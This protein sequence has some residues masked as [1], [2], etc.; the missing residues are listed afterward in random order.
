MRAYQSS[1]SHH[2]ATIRLKSDRLLGQRVCRRA[3]GLHRE[4][5]IAARDMAVRAEYI[6]LNAIGAGAQTAGAGAQM[7]RARVFFNLEIARRTGRV[8]Q[9]QTCALAIEAA[10]EFEVDRDVAG[11]KL[12]VG[13][14]LA[15]NHQRVGRD[16]TAIRTQQQRDGH[17]TRGNVPFKVQAQGP[18]DQQMR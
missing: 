15:R 1:L 4:G 8:Y 18:P 16:R 6:P 14:R 10:V 2:L 17:V 11:R 9:A 12:V 3:L 13:A 7:I 5:H